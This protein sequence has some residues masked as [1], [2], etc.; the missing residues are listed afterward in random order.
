MQVTIFIAKQLNFRNITLTKS[1]AK[2]V[3]HRIVHNS[4]LNRDELEVP[5]Q[6]IY[7]QVIAYSLA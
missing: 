5:T 7:N 4:Y 2:S 3:Q 1:L 6:K